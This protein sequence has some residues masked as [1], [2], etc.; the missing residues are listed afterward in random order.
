MQADCTD[1]LFFPGVNCHMTD[2]ASHA[3]LL[4]DCANYYRALHQAL[5]KAKRSIFVLGWDIDSRIRLVRGEECD[6]ETCRMFDLVQHLATH[7]PELQ[8]YLNRWDYS[9]IMANDR[10]LLGSWRWRYHALPNVHYCLD[11]TT[12]TGACHHQ[13]IIVIDDEVAFCGG[14]DIALNRWD[15]REHFPS[16]HRRIDPGPID[17]QLHQF[18]PYHDTQMVVAGP[19]V[20]HLSDI[21]RMRWE[22]VSGH[23]P[24]TPQTPPAESGALP[25]AWPEDFPPQFNGVEVAIALTLPKWEDTPETMQV[26]RMYIDMIRSAEHF[27]YCENQFLAH[28]GVAQALNRQLREKPALRVLLISSYNPQGVMEKK[29]LWGGRVRFRDIVESGGVA[30]RVAMGFVTSQTNVAKTIRIHSKL[31]VVDDRYLRVGSSNINNRSMLMDTEC[32]LILAGHDEASRKEICHQRNDLIREHTGRE[33]EDIQHIIDSGQSPQVFFEQV[34]HSRQHL[35]PI[36]DDCYR[37]EKFVDLA[38]RLADPV[39]PLLPATI[40]MALSRI[41]F[42]KLF[43][44]IAC[45]AALAL[46]WKYTPLADYIVPERIVPMLEQVREHPF[47]LPLGIALYALA[48]ILFVPHMLLTGVTVLAFAPLQAL[49]IVMLG[50]LISSSIGFWIGGKLGLNSMRTLLGNA[51]ETISGYAKRGGVLGITVLRMLPIAPY[52]V[53]NFALGMLEVPFFTFIAGT[54]LAALPGAVIASYLGH[55]AL[56]VWQN[57]SGEN[58]G[59][60]AGGVAAWLCIVVGSHFAGRWWRKRNEQTAVA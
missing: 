27:I 22:R 18:E 60:L 19:I 29:A 36:N 23:P 53:V 25:A 9:L 1:T 15:R 37:K 57:P 38:I 3:R 16:D 39:K 31:M 43:I 8:I 7:N 40:Y 26:E 2:E 13:K 10:E 56:E 52:M 4:V 28:E 30:D 6:P 17:T 41:Q 54:F 20:Q 46:A 48:T 33:L 47:A 5:M 24:V 51:A 42:T 59:L 34:P 45:F 12:P 50:S 55:S 49:T 32:D 11:N 58:I 44:V 21:A 14:M 35:C